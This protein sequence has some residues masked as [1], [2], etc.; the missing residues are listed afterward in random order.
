[1]DFEES[2]LLSVYWVYFLLNFGEH[3]LKGEDLIVMSPPTND[4][5]IT[6]IQAIIKV[7]IKQ[8]ETLGFLIQINLF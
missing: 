1:M 3:V 7:D 4:S 6:A 8:D 2:F 5:E